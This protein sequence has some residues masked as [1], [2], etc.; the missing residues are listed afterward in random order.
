MGGVAYGMLSNVGASKY[1]VV[2][3]STYKVFFFMYIVTCICLIGMERQMFKTSIVSSCLVNNFTSFGI[4][5]LHPQSFRWWGGLVFVSKWNVPS[6]TILIGKIECNSPKYWYIIQ[7]RIEVHT[8]RRRVKSILLIILR[9]L[10]IS[11]H[12]LGRY[13]YMQWSKKISVFVIYTMLTSV[14]LDEKAIK[15]DWW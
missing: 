8:Y 10:Y 7:Y 4:I 14:T 12:L 2:S 9:E 5:P 11:R 15:R 6:V 3:K 1:F 13:T